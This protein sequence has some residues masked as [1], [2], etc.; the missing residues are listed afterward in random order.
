VTPRWNDVDMTDD[1]TP[2]SLL[3]V[4]TWR[5]D[6][7]DRPFRAQIRIA[8]DVSSGST[9]TVT[10]ADPDRALAIVRAFLT[11]EPATT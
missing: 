1:R 5:E 3:I 9:E 2:P 8:M 7:A 10:V 11:G 4:R 6:A